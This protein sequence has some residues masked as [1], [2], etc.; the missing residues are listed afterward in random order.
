VKALSVS[1]CERSR[2]TLHSLL[3]TFITLLAVM[4]IAT[5]LSRWLGLGSVIALLAAGLAL[6]P[7][8]FRIAPDVERLRSFAELGVVLLMFTIGLEIEPR[9]LWSMRR[10]VFGLGMLQVV[11]TA[12]LLASLLLLR[13]GGVKTSVL[14]GF[15]LALSSTAIGMQLLSERREIDTRYGKAAFAILLLQ[16]LAIVPLLALVPFL[17]SGGATG[18]AFLAPRLA[19]VGILLAALLGLGRWLLPLVLRHQHRS[20]DTRGFTALVFLAILSSALASEEA[21]LSMALG[22]FLIGMLLSQSEFQRQIDE[23][24]QPLK[25]ALLDLFFIAVGMSIDLGLL[26]DRGPQMALSRF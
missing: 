13:A 26:A 5:A 1:P 6:G 19:R 20:G 12:A 10:L 16:D 23:M 8:G 22:A 25:Q 9:T 3:L 24:V 7:F 2:V 18:G 11:G 17:G 14:G 4:V 15:G 21:G